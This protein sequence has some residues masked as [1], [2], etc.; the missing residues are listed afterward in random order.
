M[1]TLSHTVKLLHGRDERGF[2][3]GSEAAREAAKLYAAAEKQAR[4]PPEQTS[5]DKLRARLICPANP[6]PK[7]KTL[8]RKAAEALGVDPPE[9]TES[10]PRKLTDEHKRRLSESA[11]RRWGL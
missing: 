6:S 8:A 7:R 4:R 11:R 5:E 9:W 2:A 3:I 10:N 1:S